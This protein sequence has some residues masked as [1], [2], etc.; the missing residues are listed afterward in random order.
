MGALDCVNTKMAATGSTEAFTINISSNTTL[1]VSTRD[2]ES[3]TTKSRACRTRFNLRWLLGVDLPLLLIV[4]ALIGLFELG[5]IPNR[6]AGF[7]C[8]D[9]AISFDYTGETVTSL[10]LMTTIFIIPIGVFMITEYIFTPNEIPLSDRTMR[11]F[12]KSSWL[13]KTYLYGFMM[14]LCI[15]EVM[16]GIVGNP[17]P[18]FF[19]LCQ[20]DTAKTCNGTDF[21][22]TFECTSSYSRWYRMDSYRS[23]PSGHTSLSVYCGF[24]LAWYLQKR[25]FNWSYRSE[26]VVPVVQLLCV[27]YSA[28]C[29]LTRITDRMHHWWD[30]LIGSA[31]GLITLLYAV[32][33]L[34]DNFSYFNTSDSGEEG[35]TAPTRTVLFDE[36]RDS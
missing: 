7:F 19:A 35:G 12:L 10:I 29:S 30:V 32:I 1:N 36:R 31:I 4:L 26:L 6:K 34:N 27:S 9:A 8:N 20:P 14:N 11:A 3:H 15:V 21:V 5:I 22:S 28:L 17:R 2:I 13:F 25:A 33:F 23:F 24:F 18:V 16:K